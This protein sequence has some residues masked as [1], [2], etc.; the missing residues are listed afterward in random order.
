[1]AK[2]EI[3]QQRFAHLTSVLIVV[4]ALV[5]TYMGTAKFCHQHGAPGWQGYTIA[6]M[7]DLL[8]LLAIVWPERPIQALGGLCATFTIWANQSHAAEGFSGLIVA[9]IPP[10]LGILVVAALEKVAH[11]LRARQLTELTSQAEDEPVSREPVSQDEPGPSREPSPVSQLP[12][13]SEAQTELAQWEAELAQRISEPEPHEPLHLVGGEF[14]P[15]AEPA[16]GW[17]QAIILSRIDQFG[18]TTA[19]AVEYTGKGKATINR[20]KRERAA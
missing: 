19:Q 1:M 7:N 11:D 6:A 15:T 5:L 2:W 9:L 12:S 3:W 14:D 13:E 18:W 16:G 20:W 10:A 17:T 8:V 4:A